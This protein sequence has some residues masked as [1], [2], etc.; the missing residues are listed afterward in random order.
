MAE[1]INLNFK[2]DKNIK[3]LLDQ[4]VVL[5]TV[6]EMKKSSQHDVLKEALSAL[7]EK[8]NTDYNEKNNELSE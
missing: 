5:K 7:F 8:Y 3:I 6:R 1:K 2:V 4:L